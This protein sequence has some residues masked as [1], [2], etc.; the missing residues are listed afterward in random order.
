APDAATAA[1]VERH[2]ELTATLLGRDWVA[3]VQHVLDRDG[4]APAEV[5]WR[6]G[7]AL[8]HLGHLGDA[9]AVVGYADQARAGDADWARLRSVRSSLA[10]SRGDL[11]GCRAAVQDAAKYARVSGDPGAEASTA[12]AQAMLAAFDG[13][14]DLNL[15]AYE[16]A[17][18]LAEEA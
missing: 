16:R 14:R 6:A 1:V 18:A 5:A 15:H 4:C 13:D 7:Y 12:V 9:L 11:E 3:L 2:L 17:L 8:H 10:W